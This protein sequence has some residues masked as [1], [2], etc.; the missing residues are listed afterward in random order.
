MKE[1]RVYKLFNLIPIWSTTVTS[2][3]E[4]VYQRLSQR[5]AEEMQAALGKAVKE[6]R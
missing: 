5:F 6:L 2:N 1:K 3:E 4:E